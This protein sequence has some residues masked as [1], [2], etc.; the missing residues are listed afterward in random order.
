[1]FLV[2]CMLTTESILTGTIGG[3]SGMEVVC[4]AQ[5]KMRHSTAPADGSKLL[6]WR[7][8]GGSGVA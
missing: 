7:G 4:C 6:S 2:P 5:K 8:W 1:M 3:R